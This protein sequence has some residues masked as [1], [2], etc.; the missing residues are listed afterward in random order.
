MTRVFADAGYWIALL[1]PKDG[2]HA[3]A[4]VA[5]AELGKVRIVTSEMVLTEVLN[6]F[7]GKGELLRKAACDLFDRIR[8]NANAEIVPMTS[9]A[10]RNAVDRYRSRADKTWG[11]T[12]CTSF[13][14]MEQK[15]I[16]EALSADREFQQAGFK[17]LM[18]D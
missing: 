12:D 2:L 9:I 1:N 18:A 5:S 7:A 6:A 15:G 17:A 4:L 8:S 16:T 14:I 13:L 11:V 3:K 10:L